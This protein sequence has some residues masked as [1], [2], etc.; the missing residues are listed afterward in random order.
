MDVMY[1]LLAIVAVLLLLPGSPGAAQEATLAQGSTLAVESLGTIIPLDFESRSYLA[2]QGTTLYVSADDDPN[3]E[4]GNYRLDVYDVTEPTSPTLRGSLPG[5][6]HVTGI[7]SG[8][9]DRVYVGTTKELRIIDV[10]DPT[11]PAQIGNYTADPRL[12]VYD[13][14]VDGTLVHLGTIGEAAIIL[15][16]S[17]PANIMLVSM[18]PLSNRQNTDCYNLHVQQQRMYMTCAE[19]VTPRATSVTD[20][21][22]DISDPA[23]PVLLVRLG[24]GGDILDVPTSSLLYRAQA[25]VFQAVDTS[26]LNAWEVLGQAEFGLAL[27]DSARRGDLIYL[28]GAQN[29]PTWGA[30]VIDIGDPLSPT[31]R[32]SFAVP[33]YTYNIELLP[34]ADATYMYIASTSRV[35][36]WRAT[37]P[38]AAPI[39]DATADYVL[40]QPDLTS[41]ASGGGATHLHGPVDVAVGP[42]GQVFVADFRNSRVLVWNNAS[43]L[44]TNGQAADFVIGQPD[45]TTIGPD[46]FAAG[47]GN[48]YDETRVAT[49]TNLC[50]PEAVAVDAAANRLYVSDTYNHRVLMYDLPIT[51]NAPAATRVFGQA[52]GDFGA[53]AYN[54]TS[55]ET[56]AD[57]TLYY[58]RG[59]TIDRNGHLY[60]ADDFNGRV[61]VFAA[62]GDNDANAAG[63]ADMVLGAATMT[64][65]HLHDQKSAL[66]TPCTTPTASN[67][68]SPKDVVVDPAGNVFVTDYWNHRVLVYRMPFA[69]GEAAIPTADG[70]FGQSDLLSEGYDAPTGTAGASSLHAPIDM[71]VAADGTLYVAD[72]QNHRVLVYTNPTDGDL[73]AARTADAVFG[74][75]GTFDTDLPNQPD[76]SPTSQN[77]HTPMGMALDAAGQLYLADFENNRVLR[78]EPVSAPLPTPTPTSPPVAPTPT[79]TPDGAIL[80]QVD[81]RAD[82]HP[83]SPLIYGMNYYAMDAHTEAFLNELNLPIVR[84][85][86]NLTTRYNW[87]NQAANQGLDWFFQNRP[88]DTIDTVIERNRSNGADTLLTIPMIGWTSNDANPASC[89]FRVSV[90]GAQQAT[91]PDHPDCG[92]GVRADG[93]PITGNDPSDTS[94]PITSDFV[95]DWITHLIARHGTAAAGGVRFYNLDNET[96]LWN[97]THRDVHPEPVSYDRLRD[98]TYDYAAVIKATDPTAQTLGPVAYGWT[99]Y[100]YSALDAAGPGNWW[101]NP[102]DREAHGGTPLVVWYLQQMR[103]YEAQH[104][105]RLLDYLDLHFYPQVP[106]VTL[107]P[108]GTSIVQQQRL[109]STRSLWD[110]TYREQDDGS[111]IDEPVMLIPRMRAWVDEHYPG[112]KLAISEYNWGGLESM[113]GALAQADVLG[114]FGR[115]RLDMAMLWLSDGF[116]PDQPGAFAFRLYRNYDGQGGSFGDVSVRATSS[117]QEQLALYAAQ[118]HRDDALTLLL[119]NK[120]RTEVTGELRLS[121]FRSDDEASVYRY[122]SANLGAIVPLAN[123]PVADNRLTVVLPASSLT[124]L[125][126]PADETSPN[127]QVYLPLVR[128]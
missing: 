6:G 35:E 28:V 111:W 109:R 70:V 80:M 96:A 32:A 33:Q 105:V 127:G 73:L 74:Q 79:T 116:T 83:I 90:Y 14:Y 81:V 99:E 123:Q 15:D 86:G 37:G 107:S 89:S 55:S 41:S 85:G 17:D 62:S 51:G 100:W 50:G 108:A 82:R 112:T 63:K 39:P 124:L 54:R 72:Q 120:S 16:T 68:C 126:L 36:L 104:G 29:A 110:A 75:A 78:Y 66:N 26:D 119:I 3:P 11:A 67:L 69:Q 84:W 25:G 114:I 53:R 18:Y 60:V 118:R 98:L 93:T 42:T 121:G 5:L 103:D 92:N 20:I 94:L 23:N 38:A 21:V 61:L 30:A 24:H 8:A 47:P 77:L 46:P 65:P 45:L 57:N 12:F 49:A 13:L 31:V 48:C 128:R 27:N 9:G 117:N 40:G 91:S 102:Q 10:R 1:A 106:S 71:L 22:F 2:L 125:V 43:A 44:T 95:R 87:T 122:S 7:W 101:E 4:T 56:P 58:P 19:I 113:N 52:S 59:L 88:L 76:G 97:E 64:T 34:A 115:E